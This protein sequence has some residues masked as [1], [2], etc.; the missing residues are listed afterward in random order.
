MA[1]VSQIA[2]LNMAWAQTLSPVPPNISSGSTKPMM[3]VTASR[4]HTLFGPVYTDFEDVDEDVNKVIDFTFKP[5]FSYYG[6]FDNQKCY[7]YSAANSRFEPSAAAILSADNRITCD[8]SQ[9]YWSGNFLN[10]ATMTRLD[11]VRKMLYGGKRSTDSATVTVLERANLSQDAHSFTKYYNGAD[12]RDYTPFSQAYLTKNNVYS[13]LTICNRSDANNAGGT[14]VIRLARGNYELWSTT[15]GTVCRWAGEGGPNFGNKVRNYYSA[16]SL[17]GATVAHE[18]NAP[19]AATDGAMYGTIGPQLTARV[20]VCDSALLGNERCQA[21]GTAP[22]VVY[23]PVGLLQEFGVSPTTG[24]AKAEFGMITGSYDSNLEGGVLRK[25]MGTLDTEINPA[26]GRFC[27]INLGCTATVSVNSAIAALD[28][29]QLYGAGNYNGNNGLTFALNDEMVN[30]LFPAWGNPMGEMILQ[31]LRYYAGE[32]VAPAAKH[33][34][35]TVGVD[36]SIGIGSVTA[37]NPFTT[38]TAR[39]RDFGKPMCRPL[40]ILAISSSAVGHD[41]NFAGFAALPNRGGRSAADF[42]NLVGVKEN[43]PNTT[44]SVGSVAGG[45][46]ADCSPKTVGSLD[47]VT[48]ICPDLPGAQGSYLTAGAAFYANTNRVRTVTTTLPADLPDTALKVKTYAAALRGGLGRVEVTIPGTSKSFFLTPESSWNDRDYVSGSVTGGPT[49]AE[50]QARYPNRPAGKNDGVLMPG[51]I[52]VFKAI[53]SSATHGAFVVSWNDTQAGNDYDMDIVGFLRYDLIGS[54]AGAQVMITTDVL[55][56][57]AGALGSHGFSIAGTNGADGKYITHGINNFRDE[58]RCLTVAPCTLDAANNTPVTMTFALTGVDEIALEDPLWYAAKYGSFDTS[59][60]SY[61]AGQALTTTSWDAKRA[62]GKS[63]GGTTGL[64]CSDGIPDGYFLARRPDLLE[65]QLRD[66]LEAIVAASNA[67]PAVS[68]SQLIDGSFKYV[69]QFDPSVKKG[70]V[71]AYALDSTGNFE[72]TPKWDAGVLLENLPLADRK[73]ITNS[74]ATSGIGFNW[75]VLPTSYKTALKGTTSIT[76]DARAEALV[77]YMRG[78]RSDESPNGNRFMARSESNILGM[79]VNSTPWIQNRP[80]AFYF[81]N[82]FPSGTPSYRTFASDKSSRDKL[83]WVGANDGMLHAFKADT[84]APVMSYVP[85][86]LTPKLKDLTAENATIQAGMDGSPFTGD[87]LSTLPSGSSTWTTHLF[88]SLGRGGKGLFALDVTNVSALDETHASSIFKWQ[89]GASDDA[90]L[91]YVVGDPIQSPFSGQASPIV[92][93][94]NGK[95]AILVP[96][97]IGS[98]DGK[99]K[100][101]II[102]TDGPGADKTW[103]LGSEYYKLQTLSTDSANGMMG[104]SWIDIDNNGTADY[105]Y[106][107]DLKG[108]VWKFDIR[109]NNPTNWK[110]SF[111]SGTTPVPLYSARDSSGN[112]LPITTSPVFGFPSFGGVVVSFGTGKSLESGDFPKTTATNRMYGIYDRTGVTATWTLP[113]GTS[114][115]V[116]RSLTVQSTDSVSVSSTP[117]IDWSTKNGWYFDFPSS[118]EMLLSNPDYRSSNI[119][120]TTV[121][122]ADTSVER[123][124]YLPPGRFYFFDPVSGLPTGNTLG[125]LAD[126]TLLI[127]VPSED[128]KVRLVTDRSSRVSGPTKV[129]CTTHPTD[130][131]CC[132]DPAACCAATPTAASCRCIL[133][134]AACSACGTNAFSYRVI[135]KASDYNLCLRSF[136]A[137]IQ[138]REVPGL[139]TNGN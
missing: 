90:D 23:K 24:S 72:S 50:R 98:T 82:L 52:L 13:G 113:T 103:A 54:G 71:Y 62:D 116:Q 2:P 109:S 42:T 7:S 16:A 87:V 73:V 22:S 21:Y 57:E 51:G 105:V 34:G 135:G 66:Q 8:T 14:P 35:L 91:G 89:F 132:A 28:G 37:S 126:G 29:V 5:T 12:I 27:H 3:M 106:G 119:A 99:A 127:G 134:P 110:S 10:W 133:D 18:A 120:F 97:G 38:S 43:I 123:C 45:W 74:D 96:N 63:C 46:G 19:V 48:G 94:N 64:S 107:T 25:N 79:V 4:D 121:R 118:S 69:A 6:Y 67:A 78:D 17:G 92:Y 80:S 104:A 112:N 84:G 100:L 59:A 111:L 75:S 122:S 76:L 15:A 58:G 70:S 33:A 65:R 83:L 108:N 85:G 139:R 93:L 56:Q 9:N 86:L 136:D 30:G 47:Q 77:G 81:D 31:A 11:V 44:R 60:T 40:S 131:A 137:R 130:P 53:S 20:K 1:V 26:N 138:W 55:A 36:T 128:Q 101:L 49:V 114:T 39:D 88:S 102:K 115:L 95:F 68:S 117:T 41:R 125:E 61:G 129:D 32:S 124:Y